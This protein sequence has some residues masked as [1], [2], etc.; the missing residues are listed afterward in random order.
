MRPRA[1]NRP[2]YNTAQ[3]CP[4]LT[5]FRL[6]FPLRVPPRGAQCGSLDTVSSG[7]ARLRLG[8][9]LPDAEAPPGPA[10]TSRAEAGGVDAPEPVAAVPGS[11]LQ[12]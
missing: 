5:S 6:A 3:F 4:G 7:F 10:L 1:Q 8:R 2:V 12:L 11:P 9:G